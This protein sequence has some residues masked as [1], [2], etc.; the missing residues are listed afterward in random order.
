VRHEH[1]GKPCS[2]KDCVKANPPKARPTMSRE[3]RIAERTRDLLDEIASVE[4]HPINHDPYPASVSEVADEIARYVIELDT[5][6]VA[7][8]LILELMRRLPLAATIA[9]AGGCPDPGITAEEL[10]DLMNAAL[11]GARRQATA[12]ASDPNLSGIAVHHDPADALAVYAWCVTCNA[13]GD[14]DAARFALGS[15]NLAVLVDAAREHLTTHPHVQ[16]TPPR[17]A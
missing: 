10:I 4:L 3:Q 12:R 13:R 16:G 2:G 7:R 11:N 17:P 14:R 5:S 15:T 8:G 9:G 6:G 1:Q